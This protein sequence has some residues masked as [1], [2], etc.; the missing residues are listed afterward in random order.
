M[1]QP[2]QANGHIGKDKQ[3]KKFDVYPSAYANGWA[4]K[5]YKDAGGWKKEAKKKCSINYILMSK[6]FFVLK[7]N[8]RI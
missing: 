2:H 1:F 8:Q 5:M 7:E 6:N 3:K 4:A